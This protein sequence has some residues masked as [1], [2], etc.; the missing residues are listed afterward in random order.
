MLLLLLLLYLTNQAKEAGTMRGTLEKDGQQ[1][2]GND[3]G[4]GAKRV[5][6]WIVRG[7]ILVHHCMDDGTLTANEEA[8]HQKVVNVEQIQ[9]VNVE[10]V[11][12]A[13]RVDGQIQQL[14]LE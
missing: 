9:T 7:A 3:D 8:L 5:Q 12:I 4:L 1:Q 11:Q 13:C 14:A 10:Q 6:F 2:G